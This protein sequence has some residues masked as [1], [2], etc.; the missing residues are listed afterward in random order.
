MPAVT[1]SMTSMVIN[2]VDGRLVLRNNNP[3][4][5]PVAAPIRIGEKTRR[6]IKNTEISPADREAD[7]KAMTIKKTNAPT[8][9]SKAAIGIS[10]LVTGP[11]AFISFTMD[12]EGAGAVANEI[13]PNIKA[14]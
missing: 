8:R 14:R 4:I 13:P 11:E 12:N 9:S 5:H 10:V 6:I 1:K 2:E 3:V 7:T